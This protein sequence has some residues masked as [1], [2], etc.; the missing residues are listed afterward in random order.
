ME[1]VERYNKMLGAFSNKVTFN[2]EEEKKDRIS[3]REALTT[4][5]ANILMPKV[6]STIMLEA[7]EPMY[8]ATS[9][10]QRVQLTEG[11]SGAR[12]SA[13]AC[14]RSGTRLSRAAG[15]VHRRSPCG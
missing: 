3:V 6:I 13:A 7:A 5:D 12:G 2:P 1:L 11:R 15:S 10:L 14:G 4:A 9:F 8:L